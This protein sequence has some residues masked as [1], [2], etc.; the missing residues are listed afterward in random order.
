[1][2][3]PTEV[4]SL[5]MNRLPNTRRMCK[6]YQ[7][8]DD[9]MPNWPSVIRAPDFVG[10]MMRVDSDSGSCMFDRLK[11]LWDNP[12]YAASDFAALLR[13]ARQDAIGEPQR[14]KPVLNGKYE[15]ISHLGAGG[16]G[17]V[18]LVWS[19]ETSALYA[20][21][22][23]RADVANDPAARSAFRSEAKIWI[24]LGDHPNIAKAFYY[25]EV[26]GDLYITMSYVEPADSATGSSLSDEV[27]SGS[28]SDGLL[29]IW[30]CQIVDALNYAYT[31]GLRAHRDIK[32]GNI[33]VGREGSARLSD[34]GLAVLAE[35]LVAAKTLEPAMAG[36]PLFMSPEQFINS[37]YCDQRSDVYSLGVTLYYAASGGV[38]PFSPSFIPTTPYE[39]HR[40]LAEV[41]DLHAHAAAEPISSS[42]WSVIQKCLAK[43]P[44]DRFRNVSELRSALASVAHAISVP[45]PAPAKPEPDIWT[46]RDQ[47]NSL[48]RLAHFSDAIK[49]FDNFLA[50]FP[51]SAAALNRAVCLENLGRYTE[52]LEVYERLAARDEVAGLVNGS[53]CLRALG[54]K[55]QALEYAKRAV[56]LG[57]EDVD[58]WI[59]LGN[60][61]WS[62][63]QWDDAMSAYGTARSISPSSAT[64]AYN[65]ALAAERVGQP[66]A[67][68]DGYSAFLQFS[69]PDDSRRAHAEKRLASLCT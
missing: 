12:L 66:T 52:A 51:D 37:Q 26:N 4:L 60:A 34:F 36:T 16:N 50:A 43:R 14:L 46:L 5:W 25:E 6:F 64:S 49:C 27:A 31:H 22:T 54:Q 32:P 56:A 23:I 2:R 40:Y 38:I 10:W 68:V 17:A 41:R 47:G 55:E 53:N 8:L 11:A 30:F 45:L 24:S 65:F 13:L 18:Y 48:M 7:K 42:L 28:L 19:R 62:L 3:N 21:K 15:V 29:C 44:Q 67:A 1:M 35:S 58:C 63:D 39:M 9:L 69:A 57:R 20:L 33:L 61:A 59:T